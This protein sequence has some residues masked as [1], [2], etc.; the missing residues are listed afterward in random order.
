MSRILAYGKAAINLTYSCVG[1]C[2]W[3]GGCVNVC[4]GEEDLLSFS[5]L[6][7]LMPNLLSYP[8]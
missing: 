4:V 3:F 5:L 2:L 7:E 6:L 1:V 8:V